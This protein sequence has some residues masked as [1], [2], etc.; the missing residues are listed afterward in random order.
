MADFRIAGGHNSRQKQ[1]FPARPLLAIHSKYF[2]DQFTK[3][4][5][6]NSAI[7]QEVD[8][9][10][11][12]EVLCV[13]YPAPFLITAENVE[14]ISKLA[15]QFDMAGLLSQC[16]MYL[17]ENIK[18]FGT[19]KSLL[20]AERYEFVHLL[21]RIIDEIKSI[22]DI[23]SMKPEY[24]ALPHRTKR[25]LL[26]KICLPRPASYPASD[27]EDIGRAAEILLKLASS[28]CCKS[29]GVLVVENKRILIHK[30]YLAVYS[31]YF[32]A[33]FQSEFAERNQ[34]E[35]ELKEV[36][37]SEIL[38]LLMI[39]YPTNSD[40]TDKN[41]GAILKLADR[42]VMPAT[43][44]RCKKQLQNSTQ[45]SAARKLWFAQRYNLLD[46]QAEYAQ[47]CK[48]M[49]DVEKLRSEPEYDLLDDK[50]VALILDSVS[51]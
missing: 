3:F 27:P 36:G 24:N 12:I 39:I 20:V 28:A 38:E 21:G 47:K 1:Y 4:G 44:E 37:Y 51:A 42:F 6:S 29:D 9:D 26:E 40:I 17:M 5:H 50:T 23:K 19:A 35:I 15:F 45:I 16:E 31:E 22:A 33:L 41:V 10:E 13:I 46:L 49:S 7:L 48:E 2:K 8:Y 32:R 30:T 25:M 14:T 34:D 43:L 18:Q 11:F